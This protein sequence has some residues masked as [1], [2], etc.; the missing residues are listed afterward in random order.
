MKA[1]NLGHGINDEERASEKGEG[2]ENGKRDKGEKGG[3][4]RIV[5]NLEGGG[6]RQGVEYKW[7]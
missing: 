4:A 1:K 7:K 5:E 6:E 3:G 2:G